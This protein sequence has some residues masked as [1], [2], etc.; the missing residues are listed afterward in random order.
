MLSTVC[1]EAQLLLHISRIRI[2]EKDLITEKEI[3]PLLAKMKT[4]E[5]VLNLN[6]RIDIQYKK[7]SELRTK[8]LKMFFV[9][10]NKLFS[11]IVLN[12][13][14]RETGTIFSAPC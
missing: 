11:K 6:S 4:C 3:H 9:I 14:S 1:I 7:V 13:V 5:N 8:A 2:C 12:A 10:R